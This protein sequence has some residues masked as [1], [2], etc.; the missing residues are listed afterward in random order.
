ME[1]GN[2]TNFIPNISVLTSKYSTYY[3]F[4][5]MDRPLLDKLH[6]YT[7]LNHLPKHFFKP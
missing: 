4:K 1:A 5:K 6:D 7:I 3:Q 2:P